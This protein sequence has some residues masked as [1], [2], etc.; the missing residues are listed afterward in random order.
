MSMTLDL[1][2]P[3]AIYCHASGTAAVTRRTYAVDTLCAMC[4]TDIPAGTPC[5]PSRGLFDAYFNNKIDLIEGAAAICGHC[6]A[7][8]SKDWLQK[9]SKTYASRDGVF[10]LASNLDQALFLHRPPPPPFVAILSTTQQQHLI[11]RAPVN[12]DA[13]IVYLRMGDEIL[14][15]RRRHVIER[16]LPA[17][18]ALAAMMKQHGMPGLPAALDREVARF[19][20]GIVRE[21]VARRSD[22]SGLGPHVQTL[23][24][25]T[26]GEWW[27][28]QVLRL[29]DAQ[30]LAEQ[31][32]VRL[33]KPTGERLVAPAA[34]AS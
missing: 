4:G 11:W 22:D 1:R 12:L 30:A 13:D 7:L 26:M 8:W 6:M 29:F 18:H 24:G 14:R 16:A 23:N 17:W 2:S 15:V 9:Y 10:K 32:P 19:S 20:M 28:L 5:N 3:S 33:V 27:A 25:L 21:D 34:E 31:V